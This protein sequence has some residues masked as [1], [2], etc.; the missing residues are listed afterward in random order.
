MRPTR[1]WGIRWGSRWCRRIQPLGLPQP[2]GD[3]Y[4]L[5]ASKLEHLPPDEP[6]QAGPVGGGYADEQPLQSPAAGEG[7]ENHQ[8]G[9][10]HPHHQVD[11][12]GDEAVHSPGACGRGNANEH[13][14]NGADERG[15]DSNGE[16]GGQALQ[17]PQK[18]VPSQM[19][20]AEGMTPGG[21]LLDPG[22]I[23]RHSAVGNQTASQEGGQKHQEHE[24]REEDQPG[25]PVAA[26]AHRVTS[27]I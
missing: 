7:D 18:E 22:K 5:L 27:R 4:V 10:G 19:V 23:C 20:G 9:V 13:R 21:G 12:P 11:E 26:Q 8:Y 6:G 25:P 17:G 15:N 2:P 16:A 3:G 1:N 24:P 14:R